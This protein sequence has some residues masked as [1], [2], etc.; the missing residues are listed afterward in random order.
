MN[1]TLERLGHQAKNELSLHLMKLANVKPSDT[2]RATVNLKDGSAVEFDAPAEYCFSAWDG[3]WSNF[4]LADYAGSVFPGAVS[5]GY[6]PST[7]QLSTL[8]L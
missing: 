6:Q 8:P 4:R 1:T 2:R 5:A 7:P 3:Y